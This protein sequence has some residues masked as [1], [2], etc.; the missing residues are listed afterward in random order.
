MKQ[1]RLSTLICVA[2]LITYAFGGIG[3]GDNEDEDEGRQTSSSCVNSSW[4][5]ESSRLNFVPDERADDLEAY[6]EDETYDD[7]A[8]PV[9]TDSTLVLDI[10]ERYLADDEVASDQLRVASSAPEH[11]EVETIENNRVTLRARSA[12]AASVQAV[13]GAREDRRE[14]EVVRPDAWQLWIQN[15]REFFSPNTA[16][17][18]CGIG[19]P[20]IRSGELLEISHVPVFDGSRIYGR[21]A[22]GPRI[23]EFVGATRVSETIL[24]SIHNGTYSYEIPGVEPGAEPGAT[25]RLRVS[26]TQPESGESIE[27]QVAEDYDGLGIFVSK[28][29]RSVYCAIRPET[30][31][32]CNY[33]VREDPVMR[34]V[35]GTKWMFGDSCLVGEIECSEQSVFSGTASSGEVEFVQFGG[36]GAPFFNSCDDQECSCEDEPCGAVIPW[37]GTVIFDAGATVELTITDGEYST[38]VTL[39]PESSAE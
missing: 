14:F 38:K 19:S 4:S 20:T 25:H 31:G 21:R 5:G 28:T 13:L 30:E 2:S 12:G 16:D 18:L 6:S 8:I 17:S 33:I 1:E 10:T 7:K 24:R 34:L 29:E 22:D 32:L 11:L 36:C 23:E 15:P 35:V 37:Y 26:T 9:A 3:C 39:R 27:Y